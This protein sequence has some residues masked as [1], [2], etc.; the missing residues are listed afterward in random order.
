MRQIIQYL[1]HNPIILLVLLII[2]VSIVI[3]VVK[4]LLKAALVLILIFA[5]V[6]A[7]MYYFADQEWA[8][9]GKEILESTSKKAEQVL[10][11]EGKKL[12]EK[13][14]NVLNDSSDTRKK[15]HRKK[16]R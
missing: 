11:T 13:G 3:S 8:Q 12:V 1:S 6:S 10:K 9:K 14:M 2:V 4:K 7:V 16:N 15:I 5:V